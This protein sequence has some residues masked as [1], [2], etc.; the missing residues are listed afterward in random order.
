MLTNQELDI[1]NVLPTSILEIPS[2]STQE[3]SNTKGPF[4][5]QVPVFPLPGIY[6]VPIDGQSMRFTFFFDNFNIKDFRTLTLLFL[7]SFSFL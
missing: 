7:F 1:S 5:G 2:A 4:Y 6:S 3:D